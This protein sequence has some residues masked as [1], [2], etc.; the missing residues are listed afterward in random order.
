[1]KSDCPSQVIFK[2]EDSRHPI[3]VLQRR[4]MRNLGL[5]A[6]IITVLA[7]ISQTHAATD[8][9]G[10]A[11]IF[12]VPIAHPRAPQMGLSLDLRSKGV[13]FAAAIGARVP[14]MSW[15]FAKQTMALQ[16]GV[17]AGVWSNLKRNDQIMFDLQ[18]G[19]YLLGLPIMFRWKNVSAVVRFAH[20]SAHLGDGAA[21]DGRQRINYSREFATWHVA[22]TTPITSYIQARFYTGLGVIVRSRPLNV[23]RMSADL[24]T[25]LRGPQF[26]LLRPVF[27]GNLSYNQDTDTVDLGGQLGVEYATPPQGAF[28]PRFVLELYRGSDRR[29]QYL[30][31]RETRVN[32][33]LYMVY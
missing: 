20:I 6:L 33:G 30:G 16:I 1:M 4:T 3:D 2:S 18:N 12:P 25:E 15:E 27:A 10:R 19:D 13:D 11:T 29:G 17:D 32:F 23:G 28:T 5:L 26:W 9:Y 14:L 8:L 24:G 31:D 21:E 7:P 22:Y